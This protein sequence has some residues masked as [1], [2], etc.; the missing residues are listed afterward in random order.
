M[1]FSSDTKEE[2]QNVV[3]HKICCEKARTQ[4]GAFLAGRGNKRPNASKKC[5]KKAVLRAAF[6]HTG[7]ISDPEKSYHLEITLKR[8]DSAAFVAAAM[9]SFGITPKT[10][11]RNESVVV[12]IKEGEDIVVFLNAIG[13]H[14]ALMRFENVRIKKDLSNSLNRIANFETA[15]LDKTVNASVR[16][17]QNIE[18]INDKIGIQALPKPLQ[19]IAKLRME[20]SSLSLVELGKIVD[21]PIGKS[22]VNHRLR[23]LDRI[24]DSIRIQDKSRL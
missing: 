3:C 6:L 20:N 18:Y 7:T 8:E 2:L 22:G 5:C 9:G 1:S 13:A 12:Y 14:G 23:K 4:S 21:P 19:E 10:A 11:R 17:T 24:A 15:N 16:H